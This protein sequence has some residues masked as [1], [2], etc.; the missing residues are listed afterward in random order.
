M[1]FICFWQKSFMSSV[2]LMFLFYIY[3]IFNKEKMFYVI[4]DVPRCP[5]IDLTCSCKN[6]S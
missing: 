2:S 6:Y 4:I 3:T 1:Q 5:P